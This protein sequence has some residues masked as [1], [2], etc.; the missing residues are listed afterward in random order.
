MR[1]REGQP[2]LSL[3]IRHPAGVSDQGIQHPRALRSYDPQLVPT[4]VAAWIAACPYISVDTARRRSEL[5]YLLDLTVTAMTAWLTRPNHNGSPAMNNTIRQRLSYLRGFVAYCVAEGHLEADQTAELVRQITKRYPKVYG[6]RQAKNPARFLTYEEAFTRLIPACSD[7]TWIGSRDN[8]AIRLGLLGLRRAELRSLTWG[9]YHHGVILCPGKG[10]KVRQVQPGPTLTDLL[11]RW[12]RRYETELGRPLTDTDPILCA[13]KSRRMNGWTLT[14]PALDWGHIIPT[15]AVNDLIAYRAQLAGLGHVAPHDL[16]RTAAS[17]LHRSLS[18]DGGH[19]YDLL[20]IQQV[21]DHAD[22]ATT[23]R[24]YLD[25]MNTG[26][27]KSRAGQ[28]I[29]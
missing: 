28:T 3:Q 17:I 11:E 1:C 5:R 20:D 25:Q 9:M 26:D 13:Q 27:V 24:S 4:L 29:D 16:R 18:P 2:G 10:N 8:V 7:G 12:R 14:A 6:K 22:P 23:Q 21:L 15:D 19:L